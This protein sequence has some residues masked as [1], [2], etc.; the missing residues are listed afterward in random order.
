[1][2]SLPAEPQRNPKNTGVGSLS[3]PSP[4]DLPDPGSEPGSPA[5]QADSL[6]TKLW[7]TVNKMRRRPSEWEK[8]FA[9]KATDEGLTSKIY[10]QLMQLNIKTTIQS[11]SEQKI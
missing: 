2:D 5:L 6:P 1:M 9:N 7:E 10:K 11:K 8:I 4:V 3:I